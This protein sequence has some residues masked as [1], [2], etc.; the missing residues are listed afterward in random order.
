MHE[1]KSKREKEEGE[2]EKER[3][4][5]YFRV[6]RMFHILCSFNNKKETQRKEA[7]HLWDAV[8]SSISAYRRAAAL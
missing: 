6:K 7:V 2:E 8:E 1:Y 3:L 5:S 4:H